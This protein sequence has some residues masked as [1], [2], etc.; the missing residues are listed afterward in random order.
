MKRLIISLVLVVL[1]SIVSLGWSISEFARLNS[2]DFE[3]STAQEE[4]TALKLVGSALALSLDND[5]VDSTGF[6]NSWNQKNQ[7]RLS[8]IDEAA[9]VLPPSLT[10]Q[11]EIDAYLLLDSEEG[12]SLHYRMPQ[13]GRVLNIRTHL[14]ST[15]ENEFSLN[16]LY[17]TLF[18]GGMVV[19]LLF[20]ISPL[21]RQLMRLSRTTKAF[22]M[23]ELQERVRVTKTSYIGAIET[24]FNRMA[25]RIQQLVEDNK[26]LS[27]AVSHDLKTPIAR[28]RFGIE[29]LEETQNEQL[30]AK[31]FQRLNRDLDTMEELVSILLSYARLDEANIQ[32][33]FQVIELNSWL[34]QKLGIYSS[35]AYPIDCQLAPAPL[36]VK[37]DPKYL[38]MQLANLL[39]NAERFGCSAIYLCLEVSGDKAWL[40]VE[41]DGKGIDISE[42]DLV[43]KPFVRGQQS[44]GNAGHGMGLAIVHRIGEWMGTR[45]S[46][47]Y[48]PKLGGAKMS[49]AFKIVGNTYNNIE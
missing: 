44:R 45:L 46:I 36:M 15:E 1:A 3:T 2:L 32:P 25:D 40:H 28:L 49:L 27:R 13:T 5:D 8:I 26:L 23:G 47:D 48:S 34:K 33:E 42:V 37:T 29:A 43:V 12:I 30:R 7:H 35:I 14:L 17:T 38:S 4:L 16:E 22:G 24:E 10:V 31:Y 21:I 39:S 9:F 18:Y 41:D 6:V 11:F 20:W 19:I